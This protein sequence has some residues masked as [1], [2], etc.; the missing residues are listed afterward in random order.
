MNRFVRA[1]LALVLAAVLFGHLPAHA[2]Q[3]VWEVT[4][5]N[6]GQTYAYGSE[7]SRTWKMVPPANHLALFT[8]YTNEPFANGSNIRYDNFTFNFP[9]VKMGPDGETFFYHASNGLNLPVAAK[10]PGFL[11]ISQIKLLPT[12]FLRVRKVHGYLTM[13]LIIGDAPLE[14]NPHTEIGIQH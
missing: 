5:P 9:Q 10:R 12:A 4:S 7:Q 3:H 11:G 13:T 6:H 1:T 2:A 14:T 8:T